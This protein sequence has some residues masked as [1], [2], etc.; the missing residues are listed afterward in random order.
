[1]SKNRLHRT[2]AGDYPMPWEERPVSRE[3]W[4]RHC[5][6]LMRRCAPGQRPEEWWI[7]E[8]GFDQV[9]RAGDE[10]RLLY[11]MGELVGRELETC[12]GWWRDYYDRGEGIEPGKR[13]AHYRWAGIPPAIVKQWNTERRKHDEPS[14]AA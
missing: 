14:D 8:K 6:K 3:R 2:G 1:M 4:E 5:E 11:E 9:P 7:Y 12:L 13:A 10:G